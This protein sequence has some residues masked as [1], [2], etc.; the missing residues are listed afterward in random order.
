MRTH[1]R[2]DATLGRIRPEPEDEGLAAVVVAEDDRGHDPTARQPNRLT[3][4]GGPEQGGDPG[5][6][7]FR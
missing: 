5:P 3:L 7:E 6:Q 4:G 2:P 1:A